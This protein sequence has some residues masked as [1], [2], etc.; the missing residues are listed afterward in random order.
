MESPLEFVHS[1]VSSHVS[2][3][4]FLDVPLICKKDRSNYVF[5]LVFRLNHT[6]KFE[7]LIDPLRVLSFSGV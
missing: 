1:Y 6:G 7:G 2:P 3:V 5:W 4:D